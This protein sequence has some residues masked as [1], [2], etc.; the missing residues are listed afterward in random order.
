MKMGTERRYNEKEIAAIFKQAA[1]DFDVAQQNVAPGEG[2]TLSE[3]EGIAR[4]V[5]ISPDFIS[6]AAAKVDARHNPVGEKKMVGLPIEVKRVATIPGE[7]GDSDWDRLV[8]DLHDT[9]GVIGS[10]KDDG[11]VRT[12]T[13]ENMHVR[14]EPA[15]SDY[16][17]RIEKTNSIA[18]I[19]LVM[20]GIFVFMSL[21]FMAILMTKGRFLTQM[22]DTLIGFILAAIGLGAGGFSARRM[23]AWHKTESKR[24]EGIIARTMDGNVEKEPVDSPVVREEAR[25]N[26]DDLG[27]EADPSSVH[28]KGRQKAK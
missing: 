4:E 19:S 23:P 6:R 22:D 28:Q 7:F 5:G 2:L 24:I 17:L 8:V 27:Y 20:G 13:S 9:F 10:T 16:R 11:R 1:E 18:A 14:V 3:I 21:M 26:I 15:G 25:L 12:W